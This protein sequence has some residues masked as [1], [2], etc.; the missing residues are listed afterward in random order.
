M[1]QRDQK[2]SAP[3][4]LLETR[5]TAE[6]EHM[7]RSQSPNIDRKAVRD[8]LVR[9][10]KSNGDLTPEQ[11][12]VQYE[13]IID[14][15]RSPTYDFAFIK[16]LDELPTFKGGNSPFA[17]S[18]QKRID[19]LIAHHQKME[20]IHGPR[21]DPYEGKARPGDWRP[22]GTEPCPV[23]QG[24]GS[25]SGNRMCTKCGGRGHVRR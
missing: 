22:K 21:Q 11:R 19:A 20:E 17:D 7:L 6:L 8:E 10:L 1:T 15:Y 4:D 24:S 9:R 2:D 3:E 5:S 13:R 25:G 12:N 23:C 16:S 18:L 14:L